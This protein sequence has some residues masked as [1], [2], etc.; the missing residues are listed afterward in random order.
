MPVAG[1]LRGRNGPERSLSADVELLLL[2]SARASS[3]TGRIGY[4][5]QQDDQARHHR[6]PIRLHSNEIEGILKQRNQEDT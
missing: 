4:N 3:T 2:I 6:L 5:G 1:Q